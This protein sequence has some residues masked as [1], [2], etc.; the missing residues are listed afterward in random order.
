MALKLADTD[1][2]IWVCS[3]KRSMAAGGAPIE[4][5]L[6]SRGSSFL[7]VLLVVVFRRLGSSGAL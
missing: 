1:Q 6:L 4:A 7:L 2:F 5:S 3:M